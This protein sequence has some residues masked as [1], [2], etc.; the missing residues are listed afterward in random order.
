VAHRA[1][2]TNTVAV[3]DAVLHTFTTKQGKYILISKVL[4]C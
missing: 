4:W 1:P 2:E 3:Y